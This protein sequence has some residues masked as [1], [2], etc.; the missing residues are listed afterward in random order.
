MTDLQ[1]KIYESLLLSGGGYI[2]GEKLAADCGITR[3]SVWK[4][5]NAL[6]KKGIEIEAV[7]NAGYRLADGKVSAEGAIGRAAARRI[8]TK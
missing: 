8:F 6:R 5:I 7:T 1:T 3:S 2:S 4:A